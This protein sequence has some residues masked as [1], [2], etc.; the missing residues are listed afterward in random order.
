MGT[1]K[2]K[3]HLSFD[4]VLIT[5]SDISNIKS[6][7]DI[8]LNAKLE[9][10][11][12]TKTLNCSYPVMASPMDTVTGAVMA[13]TLA[14]I[15]VISYLHRYNTPEDQVK[16]WLES[17]KD[18]FNSDYVGAAIGANNE[19]LQRASLLYDAGCRS[20]CI[21]IA[22]GHM[23]KLHDFI[24]VF[25]QNFPDVFMISGNTATSAGY[26]NL[27]E[28]SGVRVG[29]GGGAGCTTRI[30]TG[31]GLPTLESL[32]QTYDQKPSHLDIKGSAAAIIADGG[33]RNSGDAAKSLLFADFIMLG[34]LFAACIESP[35]KTLMKDGKKYKAYRGMASREAQETR[36]NGKK[37][38]T[39]E[40]AS[41]LIEASGKV[42]NFLEEFF[43]GVASAMSYSDSHTLE[44]YRKKGVIVKVT[45]SSLSE[46]KPRVL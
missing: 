2:I 17:T 43:G 25:K 3:E 15:E 38:L 21:D 29:I 34:S 20:F 42:V 30:Q 24:E 16:L 18:V 27:S 35:S 4:D 19:D 10:L 40:G 33:I 39:P 11:S 1:L 41:G 13:S 28:I 22:N 12:R 5:P 44:E 9:N 6:R 37:I 36:P 31:V 26:N 8:N 45:S 46:S 7:R 14:Q 32:I 23:S